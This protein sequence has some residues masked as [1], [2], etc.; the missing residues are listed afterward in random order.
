MKTPN[1][2]VS[3]ILFNPSTDEGINKMLKLVQ[4]PFEEPGIYR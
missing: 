2:H 4:R 1:E 3:Q